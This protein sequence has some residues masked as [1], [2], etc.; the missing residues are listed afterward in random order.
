MYPQRETNAGFGE[1][2]ALILND[3]FKMVL[4]KKFSKQWTLEMQDEPYFVD[5]E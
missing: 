3:T 1:P 2:V 5:V 4:E